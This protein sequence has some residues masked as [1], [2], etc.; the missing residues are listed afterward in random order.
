MQETVI[1]NV[2]WSHFSVQKYDQHRQ[3]M[4][5]LI[6]MNENYIKCCMTSL[7]KEIIIILLGQ[8][9]SLDVRNSVKPL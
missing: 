8:N 1:S 9:G 5:Y 7:S 4:Y 3:T 6:D 2:F